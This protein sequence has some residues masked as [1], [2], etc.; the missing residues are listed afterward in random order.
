MYRYSGSHQM[1]PVAKSPL[2]GD[3]LFPLFS[4]T[5]QSR[6]SHV[7]VTNPDTYT[8]HVY[9]HENVKHNATG[10]RVCGLDSSLC[11]SRSSDDV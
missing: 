8:S 10:D 1:S 4:V 5:N 11:D 9:S 6:T 2:S 3:R 7:S